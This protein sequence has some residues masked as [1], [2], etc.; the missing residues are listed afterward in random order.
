MIKDAPR[1]RDIDKSAL[2]TKPIPLV[3]KLQNHDEIRVVTCRVDDYDTNA[4]K[5]VAPADSDIFDPTERQPR[6]LL[7]PGIDFWWEERIGFTN[8]H[9]CFVFK[10]V[11]KYCS[12]TQK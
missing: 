1:I 7:F 10:C 11:K 12:Y 5:E 2:T 8:I 9:V 4:S 3:S 6:R